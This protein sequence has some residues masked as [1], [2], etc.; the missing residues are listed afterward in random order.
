MFE[1]HQDRGFYSL[2]SI[3]QAL[4]KQNL[5]D[6]IDIGLVSNQLHAVTGGEGICPAKATIL[7]AIRSIPQEYPNLRCRSVDI[8]LPRLHGRRFR[9]LGEQLADEFR[10]ESLDPVVV[11]RGG[12][13][14]CRLSSPGPWA[15]A[16]DVPPLR[17]HGVYLITGGMGSLGLLL[18]EEFAAAAQATLVLI[19]R[20]PFPARSEWVDWLLSHGEEDPTSLK[21]RRIQKMEGLGAEVRFFSADVSDEEAMADVLDEVYAEF[22]IVHGVIHGAGSLDASSF[23]AVDQANRELCDRQFRPKV[24][25]MMVLEKLLSGERLDFWLLQSSISSV[26]LKLFDNVPSRTR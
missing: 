11:Y 2:I 14:W 18:A 25:G 9:Q 3:A 24:M 15:P 23:F 26:L 6:A 12:Q 21:I 22:G 13:R 20:S 16:K 1:A 7:G 8:V 17:H 4:I 5:H 19:G 10:S